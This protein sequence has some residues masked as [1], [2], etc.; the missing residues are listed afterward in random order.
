MTKNEMISAVAEKL[1]GIT[2]KD[3]TTILE[4]YGEVVLETVSEDI[5]NKVPL[6]GIGSF[7]GKTVPERKGVSHMG[8]SDKEWVVPEHD[9]LTFKISKSVKT[10]I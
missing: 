8:D 4:A 7:T 10:I 3:I 1:D 9:E 5:T 6:L 2:K